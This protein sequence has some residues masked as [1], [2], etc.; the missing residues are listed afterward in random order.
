VAEPSA[1]IEW[2][3]LPSWAEHLRQHERATKHDQDTHAQA[4]EFHR[5]VEP[6]EV[7][8]F[9]APVRSTRI[10]SKTKGGAR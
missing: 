2:F 5:G 4:R 9:L 7:S 6:P 8:H 1:W 3:F 10:T